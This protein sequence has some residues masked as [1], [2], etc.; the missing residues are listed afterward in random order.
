MERL[1]LP[2]GRAERAPPLRIFEDLD[3]VLSVR[4]TD[5]VGRPG[6]R[7]ARSLA[8]KADPA[9]SIIYGTKPASW[10]GWLIRQ[11]R[12]LNPVISFPFVQSA[13][14]AQCGWRAGWIG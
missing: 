2:H 12:C 8:I 5:V 4:R 9:S 6:R 7:N 3:A 14:P 13:G 1:V 10:A 11:T